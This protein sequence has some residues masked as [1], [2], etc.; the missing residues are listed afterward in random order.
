MQPKSLS[1]SI[2]YLSGVGPK[3]AESFKSLGI[4]TVENLLYYFPSK[5]LDRSKILTSV[6]VLQHVINGYEGEITIV[7]KVTDSELIN[8]RRKQIFKA[9]LRYFKL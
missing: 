4:N 5:Y 8:Y 6:K 1:D 9:F 7:G 2:Q 3:R